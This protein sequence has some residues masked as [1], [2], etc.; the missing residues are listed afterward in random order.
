MAKRNITKIASLIGI[1]SLIMTI[2]P[3]QARAAATP[4]IFENAIHRNLK[5]ERITRGITH[6]TFEVFDSEGWL[7]GNILTVDLKDGNVKSDL[8]MSNTLTDRKVPT[9]LANEARAIAAVNGDFFYLGSATV[10]RGYV[11]KSGELLKS[12]PRWDKTMAI[13]TGNMGKML[14]LAMSGTIQNLSRPGSLSIPIGGL[15]DIYPNPNSVVLYTHIWGSKTRSGFLSG[16]KNYTEVVVKGNK[17]IDKIENGLYT[18]KLDEDMY[19]LLGREEG[20]NRLRTQLQIGDTIDIKYA[21]APDY[22]ELAY[23]LSGDEFVVK[24]GRPLTFPTN[25]YRHP[26]TAVG[27]NKDGTIMYLATIDGRSSLSRGMSYSELGQFMASLGA[28]NALNLDSGGSTQ[29]AVREPGNTKPT[30]TNSPSDGR[31]RA[32]PNGI[33]LFTTSPEGNLEGFHIK[34]EDNRV[35]PGFS[36]TFTSAPYDEYGNPLKIDT[37]PNWMSEL[38]TFESPGIL[39]AN[40]SGKGE[41]KV[42]LADIVSTHSIE[43]LGAL[44]SIYTDTTHMTLNN[45]KKGSFKVYGVDEMGYST[46]IETRDI[47]LSFNKDLVDVVPDDNNSFQ[48]APK[49]ANGSGLIEI[50]AG[51]KICHMGFAIGTKNII[52]DSFDDINKWAF[53]KYPEQVGGKVS[54]VQNKERKGN[55]I[56]LD[57][58]FRHT[59]VSR[60]AY[61]TA[62]PKPLELPKD[63]LA[64]GVWVH[65][66]GGYNHWLRGHIRDNTGKQ[67][68]IDFAN[69]VNWKGWK[70]VEAKMPTGLPQPLY[71][72]RIYVVATDPKQLNAHSIFFDDITAVVPQTVELPEREQK[73]D[74]IVVPE[75]N[76][77]RL[78]TVSNLYLDGNRPIEESV[79]KIQDSL[80][81]ALAEETETIIFAGN[82]VAKGTLQD[83]KYAKECIEKALPKG[84]DYY[85]VPSPQDTNPSGTLTDFAKVFGGNSNG[86]DKNGTRFF[87]LNMATNSWRTSNPNQWTVIKD[88][89]EKAKND[90][91]IHSL[92][93]INCAPIYNRN[94]YRPIT[95]DSGEAKLMQQMLTQFVNDTGKSAVFIHG[96]SSGVYRIS[97]IPHIGTDNRATIIAIDPSSDDK[98]KVIQK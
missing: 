41:V 16:A 14:N 50:K 53:R 6:T 78:A 32:V 10:P 54:I 60:A 91:N 15:N 70:Y 82:L 8:L 27:F 58:D 22:K 65:A 31:E 68:V 98:I 2:L 33:G 87:I 66:D 90:E 38:G 24:D 83:Y 92:V 28:W 5:D 36:R 47:T 18:K 19:L 45:G 37:K 76:G 13:T 23:A 73:T 96:T 86:F 81:K 11:V 9:E 34:T 61:V 93:M 95:A 52:V 75:A 30:I 89:I 94:S 4:N 49:V 26:R 44:S 69:P 29:M 77:W 48:V 74:S 63:P 1:L 67:H 3:T 59:T 62:M 80:A 88:T 17:I 55:I 79:K 21:T 43:V 25:P 56:R 12:S 84:M 7:R 97:G 72:E 71:L 39:S 35:F 51:D 57:Y 64:L 42:S 46:S 40:Q 85:V 20:A